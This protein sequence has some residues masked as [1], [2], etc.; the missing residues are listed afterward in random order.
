[1]VV[2]FESAHDCEGVV[3]SREH[4]ALVAHADAPLGSQEAAPPGS[5]T[6]LKHCLLTTLQEEGEILHFL[7]NIHVSYVEMNRNRTGQRCT[8]TDTI[9]AHSAGACQQTL[10]QTET[11]TSNRVHVS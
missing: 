4:F 8:A 7:L 3:L 6:S 1:M 2:R 10:D 9:G 5:S 11:T